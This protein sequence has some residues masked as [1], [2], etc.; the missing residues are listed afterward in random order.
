MPID[1]I[2]AEQDWIKFAL[3]DFLWIH[4]VPFLSD[5]ELELSWWCKIRNTNSE[6][7][8]PNCEEVMQNLNHREA[9]FETSKW[10]LVFDFLEELMQN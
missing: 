10:E 5:A 2:I 9:E 7:P 6:I 1:L 3:V 8:F 4:S